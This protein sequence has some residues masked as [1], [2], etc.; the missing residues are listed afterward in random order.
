[1]QTLALNKGDA[2]SCVLLSVLKVGVTIGVSREGKP[3]GYLHRLKIIR[4]LSVKSK[5]FP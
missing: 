5:N 3:Y 1:M 4:K 2:K